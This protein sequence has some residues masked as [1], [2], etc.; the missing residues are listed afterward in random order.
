MFISSWNKMVLYKTSLSLFMTVR[1]PTSRKLKKNSR[2][3][4]TKQ[5]MYKKEFLVN[6]G[7]KLMFQ[8]FQK[9]TKSVSTLHAW[10]W[11]K[12][13][14]KFTASFIFP[15]SLHLRRWMHKGVVS[16]VTSARHSGGFLSLPSTLYPRPFSA[17]LGRHQLTSGT[18][19]C[20]RLELS[21]H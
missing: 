21:D 16:Q 19:D 6:R 8:H 10:T 2:Y 20:S 18:G 11:N 14:F 3:M 1:K 5:S 17:I 4:S 15:A 9:K 13:Y 7:L 12:T